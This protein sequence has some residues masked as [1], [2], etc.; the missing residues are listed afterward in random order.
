MSAELIMTADAIER[1][2][3]AAVVAHI[4]YIDRRGLPCIVP[5]SYAY[6]GLALY[7]YSTLGA[8][9]ENMS[10]NPNVCA[11]VDRIGNAVDWCSVFV[12]GTFEHLHGEDAVDAV[13]RISA[14]MSIAAVAVGAPSEA[15]QTFVE[16]NRGL[17][18]AYRILITE[19]FGRS[20]VPLPEEMP[21]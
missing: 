14:R 4:G 6:D 15:A 16:R 10:A 5:I 11:E 8:K 18:I 7:G 17:G 21:G 2:L 19:K 1:L 9:I 13:E 12:R 20:S 3:H